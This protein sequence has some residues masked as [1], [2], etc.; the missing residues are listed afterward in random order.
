M[1]TSPPRPWPGWLIYAFVLGMVVMIGA[2]VYFTLA[3]SDVQQQAESTSQQNQALDADSKDISSQVTA[4][5]AKGGEPS[6]A[7]EAIGACQKATSIQTQPTPQVIE[8]TPGERGIQGFMGPMGP[9]G[10]QGIPGAI[11]PMGIQG[12]QG[13]AGVDGKN[14]KDGS[15]PPC[16]SE[17]AQCRGANGKDGSNGKDGQN[18]QDGQ[19]GKNGVDGADAPRPT[20]AQFVSTDTSPP[21]CVYRT[22]YDDGSFTDAP[23]PVTNCPVAPPPSASS[24]LG[25]H[26]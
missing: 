25:S 9:M 16:L 7:L 3:A 20:S 13:I 1:N 8:G 4:I 24:Q 22:S 26:R 5:C 2:G 23:T 21:G 15:S 17:A 6:K 19:N 11:G 18:G 14:G 12:K 10:I